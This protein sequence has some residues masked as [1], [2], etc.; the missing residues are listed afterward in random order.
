[1]MTVQRLLFHLHCLRITELHFGIRR[2]K[3]LLPSTDYL[4]AANFLCRSLFLE[5]VFE[6]SFLKKTFISRISR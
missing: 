6:L 3:D 4:V 5:L 1:M 2:L